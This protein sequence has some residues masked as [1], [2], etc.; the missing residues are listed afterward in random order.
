MAIRNHTWWKRVV[1]EDSIQLSQWHLVT[2]KVRLVRELRIL[3]P[4]VASDAN[5]MAQRLRATGVHINSLVWRWSEPYTGNE[6]DETRDAVDRLTKAV[7]LAA[8]DACRVLC[9]RLCDQVDLSPVWKSCL[10]VVR[11][12]SLRL[13]MP[14][15][16]RCWVACITTACVHYDG[17]YRRCGCQQCY[18][19][20]PPRTETAGSLLV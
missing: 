12:L 7:A 16:G 18:G 6:D 17:R 9:L 14:N 11:S 19:G 10:R 5:R 20:A 3:G 13:L 8:D 15:T 2:T 4:I 1:L